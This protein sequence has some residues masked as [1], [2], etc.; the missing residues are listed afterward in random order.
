MSSKKITSPSL[1]QGKN[2][3]TPE[4]EFWHTIDY[5]I[6]CFRH[7]HRDY[8]LDQCDQKQKADVLER[9]VNLSKFRWTDVRLMG[10]HQ[11][12]SEKISRSSIK[13]SIPSSITQDIEFFLAFRFSGL[14]PMI[15]FQN[16]AVF[17]IVYIDPGFQVY[18]H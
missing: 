11:L 16:K 6:F 13:P 18:R 1:N 9:V 15:G 2:I 10:R 12:G 8:C 3:K 5:P 4:N 7:L 17:H 14:A